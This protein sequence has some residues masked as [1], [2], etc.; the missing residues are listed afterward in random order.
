MGITQ[1]LTQEI[2]KAK[3]AGDTDQVVESLPSKY[4]VM[5]S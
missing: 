4:V 5:S 2:T 1:N 3:R